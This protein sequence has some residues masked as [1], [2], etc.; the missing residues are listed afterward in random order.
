MDQAINKCYSMFG[1][2]GVGSFPNNSDFSPV[3]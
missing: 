2:S 3:L 1:L